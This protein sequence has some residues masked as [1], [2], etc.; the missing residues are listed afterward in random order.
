M[1]DPVYKPRLPISGSKDG[2][3]VVTSSGNI[4]EFNAEK[5]EWVCIGILPQPDVVTV[6]SDGLVPPD[7]HRKLVLIQELIDKGFDFSSFKLDTD[8]ANPYFYYLHSSDDLIKFAPEKCPEPKEVRL[9]ATVTGINGSGINAAGIYFNKKIC[10]SVSCV[11]Y[12]HCGEYYISVIDC[13]H[14]PGKY[15]KI[16]GG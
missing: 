10:V 11:K 4:F 15:I 3:Q 12:Y 16:D 14:A 7:I 1:S 9:E 8:V 2:D 13:L 5:N 6:D